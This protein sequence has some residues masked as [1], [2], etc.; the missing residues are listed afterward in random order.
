MADEEGKCIEG[1]E[2]EKDGGST[3]YIRKADRHKTI[4]CK[5]CFKTMRGNTL[6]RHMKQ[7]PDLLLMDDDEARLELNVRRQAYEEKVT[8]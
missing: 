5:V 4:N 2:S 6:R 7:H 8:K 1:V 3:K